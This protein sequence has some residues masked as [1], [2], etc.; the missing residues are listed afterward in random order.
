MGN[1]PIKVVRN[2][3]IELLRLY[4]MFFISYGHLMVF[5]PITE[6][7]PLW[8]DFIQNCFGIGSVNLF[9]LITGYFLI[10]KTDYTLQRFF[11]ILFETVFYFFLI[12]LVF[13]TVG[14]GS[15]K[16]ILLSFYPFAPSKFS[17]WFVVQYFGLIL[18]QPFLSQF[19]VR[20][21]KRQYKGFLL[22]LL[23]LSTTLTPV[24]PWG[25]LYSSSWKMWWFI[26]LFFTG[27]YLR[28]HFN[29]TKTAKY[30]LTT[31]I[32]SVIWSLC[33]ISELGKIISLEY[34]SILT[35]TIA[36]SLFIGIK[37]LHI[38]NSKTINLMAS[39]TFAGYLI[40]QN[41]FV[42]NRLEN[43]I[44]QCTSLNY[45]ILINFILT[46]G[47]I[48]AVFLFSIACDIVRQY[49]F[50]NLNISQFEKLMSDKLLLFSNKVI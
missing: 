4:A 24:F 1:P 8:F 46:L 32:L 29:S 36:I 40:H 49:L 6:I 16:D 14:I 19:A 34:N 44:I 5:S 28:L 17:V 37:N 2:S 21:S 43:F 7:K 41:Y 27:G 39:G 25:Y 3:S 13:Y 9:I 35:Y 12:A 50:K 42:L 33:S 11:K 31:L 15:V 26:V 18:I 38:K 45:S 23:L 20:L 48:I 47:I 22:I 30:L 10:N